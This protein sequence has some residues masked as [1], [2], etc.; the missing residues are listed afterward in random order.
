MFFLNISWAHTRRL[1]PLD[2]FSISIQWTFSFS[3]SWCSVQLTP[4]VPPLLSFL[5]LYSPICLSHMLLSHALSTSQTTTS[6]KY[7]LTSKCSVFLS[8]QERNK[9]LFSK[10]PSKIPANSF[11]L[12]KQM[13]IISLDPNLWG[14]LSCH[15]LYL[16]YLLF[17][18][19]LKRSS[20]PSS[21]GQTC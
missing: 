9:K 11:E 4:T 5:P 13:F 16:V 3:H 19:S 6:R 2:C 15:A 7:S 20:F 12:L 14:L 8:K 1:L 10:S 21:L 17:T 18:A